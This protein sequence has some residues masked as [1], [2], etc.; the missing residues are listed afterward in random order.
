MIIN[1]FILAANKGNISTAISKIVIIEPEVLVER[2]IHDEWNMAKLIPMSKPSGKNGKAKPVMFSGKI[3]IKDGFGLY[4]D[5]LGWGEDLKGK[6]FVSQI[7]D[8]NAEI[9]LSGNKIDLSGTAT[10]VIGKAVAYTRTVGNLN[11]RTGKYRFVVNAKNVDLEKWGYYTMNIPHFK[12]ISGI[13]DMKLTMTN[14]PPRKKGLPIFFDGQFNV[15]NG[16]AII[17]NRPFEGLNGFVWIHDEDARFNN[18]A[19]FTGGVPVI[20][21]GRIY[22]FTVANYDLKLEL[23]RT[24]IGKLRGAFPGIG[25]IDLS[26]KAAASVNIG[27]DFAHPLFNGTAEADG[28]LF[29]Q[30]MSGAF[31]FKSDGPVLKV[32]SDRLSA[33]GGDLSAESIFDFT[34]SDPSFIINVYGVSLDPEKAVPALSSN[35]GKAAMTVLVK[36]SAQ[37][38]TVDGQAKISGSGEASVFGT[39]EANNIDMNLACKDLSISYGRFKG[40]LDSLNGK[41]SGNVRDNPAKNLVF[42]GN[43][44][45]SDAFLDSQPIS[46][47]DIAFKY[48]DRQA[49]IPS[50]ILRSGSSTF[51]VKGR[52]GLNCATDLSIEAVSAEVSDLKV[53]DPFIPK[54]WAP[55][56]GKT[57]LSISATGE[58]KDI[59]KIDPSAF[60]VKGKFNLTDGSIS[61]QDIKEANINFLWNDSRL[62]LQNCRITTE[63]SDILVNGFLEPAGSVNMDISGTLSLADLRPFTQKYGRLFGESKITCHL[64]GKT[65]NPAIKMDLGVHGLRFNE[66]MLSSV[67]GNIYYDGK[68]LYFLKPL[69]IDQGNDEYVI[70][71]DFSFEKKPLLSLRLDVLKGELGTASVLIDGINSEIG[72]KQFFG[73]SQQKTLV[74]YPEKFQL[75]QRDLSQIYNSE[76]KTSIIKD[77]TRAE[78]DS[79]SY[80]KALKE[81]SGRNINGKF[82]GFLEVNGRTDDLSGA[83]SFDVKGGTWEGYSFDEISANA[84]MKSGTFEISS[85]YIKKGNGIL[86]AAGSFNFLTSASLEIKAT[87]MPIDFLS[88]FTGNEKSFKGDVD[89]DAHVQGPVRSLT[90]DA[91]INASN[92]TVGGVNFDK[93][94]SHIDFRNNAFYFQNTELSTGGKK[95]AI[96]GHIPLTGEGLSLSISLEG[97]SIG[98]L[99]LASPNIQWT[100]GTGEGFVSITGSIDHPKLNGALSIKNS[101]IEL[102]SLGSSLS[103]INSEIKINNNVISTESLSAKWNGKWTHNIINKINLYGSLDLNPLFSKDP[104][105]GLN[106]K[107]SDND[108]TVDIPDIYKGD[109]DVKGISLAGPS[110]GPRLSG[111]INLSNGALTLPDMSR[112]SAAFPLGMNLTV[113]IQKNSYVTAGDVNNLISTDLS[114]LI[115]NLELEG[116]NISVNGS[117]ADPKV[118]GKVTFKSG[119]VNILNREFSLMSEDRQK[120]VFTSNQMDIQANTADFR[121]TTLP[122]LT[123]S[124]EIN[125]NSTENSLASLPSKNQTYTTS[126]FLVIS[127]ITGVPF[128]QEKEE[129]LNLMFYAFKEDATK[130]PPELVPAGYDEEQIKVLLLP[131]FIKGSLGITDK[132][133]SNVDANEVLA[134]YLNSRLNAYLLRDVERNLA[135]SFELESLT[136]EYNFGKDLRNM[137]TTT[138][139]SELGP[140][141]LPETMYGIGAVKS[142]FGRLFIDVKYSQAVEQPALINKEWLN[143]QLT[144]KLNSVL[145]VVYYREPFSFLQDSDYYKVTLKAGYEF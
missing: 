98:L 68:K 93:V 108:L 101:E 6:A 119:T 9:K 31:K 88:F 58:I 71:G 64:E 51:S 27:G 7:K 96:S 115:L 136:L 72:A 65:K 47:A 60:S 134:D 61:Y 14:P 84:T 15:K 57:D 116:N 38:F 141:E 52:T 3:L 113:N 4:V 77:V 21:N 73:V 75:P 94:A 25:N 13:S 126:N 145:S 117:L 144:Y 111:T 62:T 53:L 122:Y 81:R 130:Q 125:I 56:T 69:D 102:M 91:G 19:G 78:N 39:I 110:T 112:K 41:I 11:I 29:G 33:Y 135:K 100:S 48:Y 20:A 95:S 118:L 123:L 143:Y 45:L 10:S 28:R 36:G 40:E 86:S 5:H 132:G 97:E 63:A 129:G 121:G 142:F 24:D 32:S 50:L 30:N 92:I 55:I 133:V 107:L 139:P 85:A 70:S 18:V 138:N 26:G 74:I 104:S 137:F 80:G 82:T 87:D 42:E 105:V 49:E 114:N 17:F 12:P 140:Q 120:D 54:E 34:S 90:G 131:D 59:N 127:R 8:F 103:S 1:P 124:A 128:S 109:L 43:A 66:I 67:S 106:L 46:E 35:K 44:V 37:K 23:P 99:S 16:K 79:Y 22:D 76:D 83:L 89:L 2:S